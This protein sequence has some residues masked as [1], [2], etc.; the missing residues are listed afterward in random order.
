M[1]ETVNAKELLD[2]LPR[3]FHAI[4]KVVDNLN[5]KRLRTPTRGKKYSYQNTWAVFNR[6]EHYDENAILELVNV[7]NEYFENKK[8]VEGVI[9][10]AKQSAIS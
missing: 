7:H 3:S 6:G 4:Q 2:Q 5:R 9:E 8:K 1:T 10:N